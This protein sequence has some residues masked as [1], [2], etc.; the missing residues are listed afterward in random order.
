M[1][2]SKSKHEKWLESQAAYYEKSKK[3]ESQEDKINSKEEPKDVGKEK[4]NNKDSKD[5]TNPSRRNGNKNSRNETA[6]E[7]VIRSFE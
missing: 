1:S 3:G 7:G 6:N 2:N 4:T 5:S